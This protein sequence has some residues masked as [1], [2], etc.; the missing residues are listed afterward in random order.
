LLFNFAVEYAIR[1]IKFVRLKLN[2]TRQPLIYAYDSV[3]CRGYCVTCKAGFGLGDWIYWH[4][5]HTTRDYRQYSAITDLHTVQFTITHALGFSVFTSR[6]L[7]T[8]LSQSHCNIWS[9]LFTAQFLPCYFFSVTLDCHL[10][11]STLY[12]TT[13]SNDLLCPFITHWHGPRRKHSLAVV[14]KASLLIRC[15]T[16]DVL[17]LSAYASAGMCLPSRCLVMGL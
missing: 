12:L 10:Q 9:L 11:N 17:L 1:K 4:L 6:I 15:L 7:A 5:I 3:T 13:H 14:E 2:G 16:I 8:D